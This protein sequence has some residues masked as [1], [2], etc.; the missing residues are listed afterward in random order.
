MTLASG[1]FVE[2]LVADGK[3]RRLLPHAHRV[4]S[5]SM[6]KTFFNWTYRDVTNFLDEKG[7]DFYEDLEHSQSWV[8][9]QHNGEPDRFVEI[10]FT[11]GF[12]TSKALKKMI[13]QSGSFSASVEHG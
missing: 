2:P 12:Y 4:Y 8:K 11:Q 6:A 9:L 5:V 13:R 10:K 7:F 3:G 1:F